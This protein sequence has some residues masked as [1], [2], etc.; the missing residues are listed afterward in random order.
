[1]MT[2]FYL[3]SLIVSWAAFTC[4]S[5]VAPSTPVCIVGAGPGGLTIAHELES[6]GYS[7]IVFDK[8]PEV[9]GKCQEYY[10][11]PD[12]SIYHPLGALLFTNETYV[13]T[14][15]LVQAANLPITPGISMPNGWQYWLY[16]P[17]AAASNVTK[18]PNVTAAQTA[19][20]AAEYTK[21]TTEWT[22]EFA[23][24]YTSL[25]YT[26]GVPQD[27]TVPMSQWLS[28][29]GYVAL[30]TI[31]EAGMVPYGYGDIT[32]T[33]A[34]FTPDVLGAFLGVSPGYIVD[35][36]KVFVHY[37]ESV[38]GTVH[39]NA[40]VTK[41]DRSG[42]CPVVT[43]GS[44]ATQ[45]CAD[46]ILAFP[47]T[48]EN[49]QAIDMPL[50]SAEAAVFTNV[51]IT[52]YWSSATS[53]KIAYP[54]FYQ[55][56][57]PQPL[58]A[59]VGFL[60]VFNDSPVAT[61]YSWGPIGS[62]MSIDDVTQLL[63]TT[64]TDVQTGAGITDPTVSTSDVKSIRK[65]D[66]FPHFNTSV[67][68]NGDVYAQYNALQGQQHTYYSSGLNGFETVEFAIRAAKDLVDSFF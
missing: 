54:Y 4:A 55:Q 32:Q 41:I 46:V 19:L 3:A 30:P 7:T 53:T 14:L 64:L 25:R 49:L 39:V 9:G 47:P 18:M 48:L 43:Y 56:S 31:M 11:G 27:L 2:A 13:N 26:H 29:H 61:T 65:W 37:S 51:G 68:G 35:F 21:Y 23:P 5:R 17:G 44:N 22:V 38:K 62:N 67:L 58:G 66:Y 59:P 57:P 33:P 45:T 10:D 42:S 28:S 16:G 36:H 8:Q 52:A 6:K 40:S 24:L 60:R 1:M 15:P 12:Q 20:I 50:S 34:Y 63:V